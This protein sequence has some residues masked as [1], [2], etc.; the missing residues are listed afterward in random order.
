M[1]HSRRCP[2]AAALSVLLAVVIG[3]FVLQ[4]LT[5]PDFGW[6]L[7]TGMDLVQHAG[8]VPAY[9]PYSHTM[10]DWPWVEHAWL[11]DLIM[12]CL[13]RVGH[14]VGA[15][16]VILFF[17]LVTAS[18]WILA[19]KSSRATVP[20]RLAACA[21]SLWVAL[22]F[23]GARTQ[24]LT[25]LG[26][27]TLMWLL[28][29][30][31]LG[32]RQAVWFIPPLFLG[33]ANLH[34]GF[35][36]GLFMLAVVL[37]LSSAMSLAKH[38]GPTNR[39]WLSNPWEPYRGRLLL[40]TV[41]ACLLTLINPYGWRLYR[42]IVE[43]LS[44]RFMVETLQEW[45]PVS[46]ETWAGQ[47]FTAYVV[48]LGLAMVCCYRRS[49]PVRW[50]LW[51]IFL[52]LACRHARNIPLLL[53]VS[54]PLMADVLQ[55]ALDRLGAYRLASRPCPAYGTGVLTVALAL[56]LLYL[57]PSHLT[58][59]WHF[60]VQPAAAFRHTSYPIEAVE[61]VQAHRPR[62][63]TRPVHD[64]QYGGFLLWWLPDEKVFI[65]GR[66]PAW[67]IGDRWIFR[68]YVALR[69]TDPPNLALL[70]KYAVDWALVRRESVL[71]R[72]LET[73]PGWRKEYEDRKAVI[74]AKEVAA[75]YSRRGAEDGAGDKGD[76]TRR[77]E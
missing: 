76:I 10:P 60:G 20:V 28:H 59:V 31:A 21:L 74:F 70:E 63:G 54:L 43:S 73:L 55:D 8:H 34:G 14:P 32:Q 40:A 44:D 48:L 16:A 38:I 62:L 51:A 68:D 58:S 65:D 66:M 69:E 47:M 42:E 67:R 50:G 56:F 64:Y 19:A 17:G 37:G 52:V 45:Q 22:P 7:R 39:P 72:S 30:L 9:D 35:L 25:L 27:A 4:P 26:L 18:A 57:G 23:L 24:M 36:A 33:W 13:Y 3:N 49:E 1:S 75:G 41:A 61:W 29:R 53:I 12:G 46:L 5:E 6:H 2:S 15:L 11:T 71:A 77:S